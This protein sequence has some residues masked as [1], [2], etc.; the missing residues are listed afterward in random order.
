[1]AEQPDLRWLAQALG[2]VLLVF[3]AG[4]LGVILVGLY[5]WVT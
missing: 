4:L 3:V 2:V 1:M 5:S